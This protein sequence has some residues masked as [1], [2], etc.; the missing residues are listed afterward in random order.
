M[1]SHLSFFINR[2]CFYKTHILWQKGRGNPYLELGTSLIPL[3][4]FYK[5]LPS[6]P[7]CMLVVTKA[8]M[9]SEALT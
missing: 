1:T 2:I 7:C 6:S 5:I 4:L 8:K 9:K 3:V